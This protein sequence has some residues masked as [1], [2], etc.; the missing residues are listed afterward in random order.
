MNRRGHPNFIVSDCG[1]NFRGADKELRAC[2]QELDQERIKKFASNRPVKW[3]FNPPNAPHMGGSWERLVRSVKKALNAILKG[4]L[5][6]DFSLVT[7][8][9]E[10]E[11]IMNSRPL[12]ATSD[13]TND[14]EALT[15]NHCLL[16]RASPNLPSGI[17]YETDISNRK[18]WRQVQ[19]LT[20]SIFLA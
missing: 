17:F 6:D 14:L 2:L 12:T 3:Q 11:S 10:A 18:R 19:V 15:P 8:F 7:I 1:S 5:V 9:T 16:G 20:D 4:R 13:D